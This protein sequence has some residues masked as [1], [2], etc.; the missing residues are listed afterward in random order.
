MSFV[1]LTKDN[2]ILYA[3]KHYDNPQCT[4]VEEFTEDL[5][6][7]K[8]IRKLLTI[9]LTDRE[10]RE[11]LIINHIIVFYNVFGIIP[12]TRMLFFKLPT[13]LHPALKTFLVFLNF[14]PESDPEVMTQIDT[15]RIPTD[16]NIVRL[17]REI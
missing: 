5:N 8:Y 1:K 7:V 4:G 14:L 2:Y 17:L 16:I 15:V 12:A 10:L 13:E 11:R 6:R 3:M 9:Y